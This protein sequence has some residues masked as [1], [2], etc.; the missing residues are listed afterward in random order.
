MINEKF[1]YINSKGQSVELGNTAP[2]IMLNHDG[3]GAVQAH[4]QM[5]KSPFQD[6]MT[7]IDSLLEVRPINIQLVI[8]APSQNELFSKRAELVSVFSPKLGPGKL[9]YRT[10]NEE[11]EIDAVVELAPVFPNGESNR[12]PTFQVAIISLLCPSPFWQ[13]INTENV[14]LEDFVSNF[15]FSFHFPVRFASRGDSR[16]LINSGDVPTPIKVTFKG[17]AIN[18]KITNLT[19]GEFIR[20][21][22]SIPT[23]YSLVINTEFGNKTVEII[24]PDG[25]TTNA[26]GYIDLDSTFFELQT[27]ENK[28]SFI[29]DGGKPEVYVEYK[30]KYLGV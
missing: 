4:V 13:D 22:R 27:G 17:E 3:V 20:V 19:T 21:N 8:M 24:A 9:R 28:F 7:Y 18:P 12:G 10:G 11:K 5:Q 23:D 6:G 29:T 30:H 1:I 25:V 26:L 16:V 14:K 2:F 15:R